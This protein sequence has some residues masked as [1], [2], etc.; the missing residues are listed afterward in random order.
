MIISL[1]LRHF[2]AFFWLFK[3]MYN[4]MNQVKVMIRAWTL[5][6]G[7][8]SSVEWTLEFQVEGFQKIAVRN[9]VGNVVMRSFHLPKDTIPRTDVSFLNVI[10]HENCIT[11][12]AYR[13]IHSLWK[14]RNTV[15]YSV[16]LNCLEALCASVFYYWDLSVSFNGIRFL[17]IMCSSWNIESI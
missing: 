12:T 16:G 4:Y 1:T 11:T 14:R 13:Y 9:R 8:L 6:Q 10:L 15:I 17:G 7:S 5:W 3:I 2:V